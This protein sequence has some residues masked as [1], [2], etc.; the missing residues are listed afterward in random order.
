MHNVEN[1][2]GGFSDKGG[3]KCYEGKRNGNGGK[4]NENSDKGDNGKEAVNIVTRNQKSDSH[5]DDGDESK[6]SEILQLKLQR[7]NLYCD[8]LEAEKYTL[9]DEVSNLQYKLSLMQSQ[10]EMSEANMRKLWTETQNQSHQLAE[11][12]MQLRD[13][14]QLLPKFDL[15]AM[16]GLLAEYWV[17]TVEDLM[18]MY[19]IDERTIMA[20]I[21][22]R[23][24]GSALAWYESKSR[25]NITWPQLKKTLQEDFKVKR[26]VAMIQNTPR[27]Y[28]QTLMSYFLE[29]ENMAKKELKEEDL[30][31][32]IMR[33]SKHGVLLKCLN[34]GTMTRADLWEKVKYLDAIKLEQ[35]DVRKDAVVS[36]D[37]HRQ[38][39]G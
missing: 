21:R 9:Q 15:D 20:A 8:N 23:W 7:L 24:T 27:K 13:V 38:E 31:K 28:G 2:N 34:E 29:I 11:S 19:K 30:T 14:K 35:G 37:K 33:G 10:L 16:D 6:R 3:D 39:S 18:I 12:K 22:M 25:N 4:N 36:G 26:S 17:K 5:S 1:N 32:A